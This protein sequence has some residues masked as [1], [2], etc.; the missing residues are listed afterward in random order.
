M[1]K[2]NAKKPRSIEI[3]RSEYAVI[4]SVPGDDYRST[5]ARAYRLAAAVED[6]SA[7]WG[8]KWVTS[9]T[10]RGNETAEVKLELIEGDEHEV[11]L[12]TKVIEMAMRHPAVNP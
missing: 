11:M 7:E 8:G 2:R 10:L 3:L 12:A 6:R 1:N 4:A 9:V 5:M